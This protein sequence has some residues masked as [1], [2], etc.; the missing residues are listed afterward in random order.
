MK[1]SLSFIKAHTWWI[2]SLLNTSSGQ[3][4]H[5]LCSLLTG[6]K[7]CTKCLALSSTLS[8]NFPQNSQTFCFL[9][10][11]EFS[12][13][14]WLRNH[15]DMNMGRTESK[16]SVTSLSAFNFCWIWALD[17]WAS[18]SASEPS[19]LSQR[20]HGK[21]LPC[22]EPSAFSFFFFFFGWL[23]F[24]VGFASEGF[25]SLTLVVCLWLFRFLDKGTYSSSLSEKFAST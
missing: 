4:S 6:L 14:L 12:W 15:S 8:Q 18:K 3:S 21:Q 17:K 5:F 10:L 25:S 19:C 16:A 22:F 23:D 24:C 11:E 9:E 20:V 13:M 2:A 1:N 7:C